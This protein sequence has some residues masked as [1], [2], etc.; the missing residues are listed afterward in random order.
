MILPI[1]L[2]PLRTYREII[3]FATMLN[4]FAGPISFFYTDPQGKT[5]R[6]WPRANPTEAD[7]R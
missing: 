1:D 6:V 2:P 3:D 4:R 7:A 5:W